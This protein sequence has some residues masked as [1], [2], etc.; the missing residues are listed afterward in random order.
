MRNTT[1]LTILQ[2]N[3]RNDKMSTMISLLINSNTQNYDIIIIQKLW[4]NFFVSTS[5]SSHQCDF[6]LLYKS[7]NDTRVCFYVN[8]NI[9]SKNWE[10]EF[11]TTNI[12][13]LSL[14]IR[15]DDASKTIYIYN[16]YNLSSISYSSRDNSFTLSTTNRSLI[17]N[18]TNHHILLK[19]FNLHYFF[20]NESFRS[21]QHAAA[22]KLLDMIDKHDL[23]LIL[24]REIII[25]E[26]RNIFSII[27]L[28]F[29]SSYLIEK[30]EHC[31]SRFDMKQSSNYI[32]MSTRI[33]LDF[34]SISTQSAKRRVW[35]LLDMIKLRE[36]ERKTFIS[37]NSQSIAEIDAYTKKIQ[38][39]L[40]RMINAIISWAKLNR[41]V[42][43]FW[44]KKCDEIIKKTRRLRRI[45]SATQNFSNWSNYMKFND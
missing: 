3:V 15:V 6:H 9:D 33:L 44:I 10:I 21:T 12:C 22:N 35:K 1:S 40:H 26:T 29:V 24:S 8:D 37:K 4:R 28:T 43:S 30:I 41:Y 20:W 2:Y 11:L 5:L 16:I 18:V 25:W 19:D 14:T 45:W 31:M 34:D 7:E 23:A 27:D 32:S 39:F 17:A 13:V 38:N 36:I 42:K